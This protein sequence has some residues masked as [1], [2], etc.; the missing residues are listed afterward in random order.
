MKKLLAG[1]RSNSRNKYNY[2]KRPTYVDLFSWGVLDS[3]Q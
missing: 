2:K 3:N 1:L